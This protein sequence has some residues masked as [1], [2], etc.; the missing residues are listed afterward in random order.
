[1]LF[2]IREWP[3]KTATLMTE[4]G[5]VLWTFASVKEAENVCEEWYRVQKDDVKY[6][7]DYVDSLDPSGSSCYAA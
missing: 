7:V 4:N 6:Y 3:N 2:F 5:V 1:M